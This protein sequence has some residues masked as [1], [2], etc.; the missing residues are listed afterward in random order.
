[1]LSGFFMI[2]DAIFKVH[3]QENV[4]ISD[5]NFW[6]FLYLNIFTYFSFEWNMFYL[7]IIMGGTTIPLI[8]SVVKIRFSWYLV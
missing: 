3:K 4:V 5:L 7:A 1:M 2:F 8:L 6:F